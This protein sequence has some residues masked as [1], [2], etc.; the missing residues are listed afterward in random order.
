MTPRPTLPFLAAALTLCVAA[1]AIAAGAFAEI[2]SGGLVVALDQAFPRV[3]R[4]TCEGE[5]LA[6]ARGAARPVELNGKPVDCRVNFKKTGDD[7]AE[8]TLTFGAE[9]VVVGLRASVS[10]GVVELRVTGIR[11]DGAFRVKTIG[12]PGDALLTLDTTAPDAAI[13]V[14]TATNIHDDYVGIFRETIGA[15]AAQK[16]GADTGNYF[17]ASAGKLAVGIAS[18]NITDIRRTAWKIT[19]A[20]G[21]KTC[22]A[23]CPA[24]TWR[25]VDDETTELPFVKV[26][27]TGDRNGDGKA[28]WQDAAL[29]YRTAMPKP[30]GHEFVKGTVGE[31]I[32]M[33]FASGAQQPFLRILDEV[34]RVALAT[35]GIGNQ[36]IIK[37]FSAEGHDSANSDYADHF[38]TRAGG[39][40]DFT[41]LLNE[42]RKYDTRIGIHINASEAYPEALRFDPE[43]LQRDAKGNFRNGWLWLDQAK[44]IDKRKDC[45]SG[46][47]VAALT[48]MRAQLPGLDFA[49]V[50]AYWENGWPEWKTARTLNGLGLPM[51]SEGDRCLDPWITW[52]HWRLTNHTIQRFL[53]YSER[54]LFNNDAILRG[55][56]SDG[57]GFMGWQG[58]HNF[59][60]FLTGTFSRHLPAKFLQHFE[61]LR[62]E[63]GKEARFSG[64]VR[65][66]KTGD[67]VTV[68]QDGREVMTWTGGGANARLFVPWEP[69]DPAGAPK[70]YVWNEVG[71]ESTRELPPGWKDLRNVYLYTLTATGRTAE[72]EIP[73][74]DGRVTLKVA[75]STPHVLYPAPAPATRRI[76]WGEGSPVKDF[77]F[78]SMGF[79]DWKPTSPD[80]AKID[81]D[82]RGNARLTLS[83][84][85]ACGVSQVVTGLTPGK[86]YLAGVWLQVNGG[87]RRASIVV[88]PK[89]GASVSNFVD[90]ST[91]THAAPNDPRSGS[92]YQYVK[93]RFTLPAGVTEA[94]LSL[95]LAAGDPKITA[96][97]DDVRLVESEVSPEAAKHWFYEDF[98]HVDLGGYGPFS[99]C[100]GE[101]THLSETHAPYTNDT[102]SGR[103][104]LKSRDANLVARTL[105]S[106]LRFKPNTTYKVSCLTKGVGH[107]TAESG[108]K[109]L[110]N[111]AFAPPAGAAIA[112]ESDK[113][114]GLYFQDNGVAKGLDSQIPTTR[115]EG[116]FSTGRAPDTF[117]GLFH[118]A[119]SDF[120]AVDELAVD[121]VGPAAP[122]IAQVFDDRLAGRVVLL[123]E[124]FDAPLSAAWSVSISGH[125]GTAV[126][127]GGGALSLTAADNVH[128]A[129][130]RAL[131]AGASAIECRMT[132]DG[133]RGKTWGPGLC[134]IWPA[135]QK[136]RI[137]ARIPDGRLN[138]DSTVPGEVKG[139]RWAPQD[140]VAL[141]VRLEPTTVV[142]EARNDGGDW[143]T[144]ATF[145]RARFPG[146]PARVRLGKMHGF[147]L[148]DNGD[149]GDEGAC[150]FHHLRVYGGPTP[151]AR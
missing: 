33:N 29:V 77:G 145:P 101:R 58:R 16:P 79:A 151:A 70:I 92:K 5:T 144:L 12:F 47:L 133:D 129:A 1:P 123:E 102:I 142:A 7:A 69:T 14:N 20:G 125:P 48:K 38:N 41:T 54:D 147:A 10:A 83:G 97:F 34:K 119:G 138:V 114:T 116:V 73:V 60:S 81:F 87:A 118:D 90:K 62:W 17:F 100:F 15:L 95:T 141:R 88:E 109:V 59:Q 103:F 30:F 136:I 43:I 46:R 143:Q 22:E 105:P 21:V 122:A 134:V 98:E 76:V 51:Y 6:G 9:R 94:K 132:T 85:E 3:L 4:Y 23:S 140:S 104:S 131:P 44:R 27:V 126:K 13:A 117:L 149:P 31:N 108:G 112:K 135:G 57:D 91:I 96:E 61:L 74:K 99:C 36:V 110:M 40:R 120:I 71:D 67:A 52:S 42:A 32:A 8:Y 56:R 121:E 128:A 64:G 45:E 78:E 127:A 63:P 66:V 2:R 89:G 37:G 72:T 55:G 115:I 86:S 106:T 113:K 111:L 68:T 107:L 146:A 24:W 35:D 139:G 19:E 11:E 39:I 50:D 80:A 82:G 137:N 49:Y 26:F 53:W 25:E 130:E 75:K 18:N 124:P 65:V 84:A 148:D 150:A 93:V 28:D